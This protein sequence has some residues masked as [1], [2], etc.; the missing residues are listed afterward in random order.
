VKTFFVFEAELRILPSN[1]GSWVSDPT[2]WSSFETVLAA[3]RSGGY[4]GMGFVL[5]DSGLT[6]VDLDHCIENDIIQPWAQDVVD[7]L[8]SY[9]EISPSGSGIHIII[10]AQLPQGNKRRRKG[11]IEMYCHGR[12]FCVTSKHLNGT[13]AEIEGRQDE[14]EALHREIFG[15]REPEPPREVKCG[16]FDGSDEDLLSRARQARNGG[17]F[18]ALYDRGDISAY[19]GD[20]SAADQALVNMLAFWCGPDPERID[21]LFRQ[22]ALC[23]EKWI[24]RA[25]YRER[26]IAAALSK[27]TEHFS[28]TQTSKTSKAETFNLTDSGNAERFTEQHGAKIRHCRKWNNWLFFDGNHWNEEIGTETTHQLALETARRILDEAKA[29]GIGKAER[30]EPI[31]WSL[32]SESAARLQAM[33][34]VAKN[35]P[36]IAAVAGDFD[37]DPWLF[38]CQNGTIDLKTGKLREHRAKDMLT[39]ISPVDYDPEVG[40]DLWDKFLDAV[41]NGDK[42]K[43]DFLRRAVG[44]ALTGVTTEE[45]LFFVHGAT[46]TG[47]STFIEAVKAM[48]GD[49]AITADFETF[50]RRKDIGTVRNDIARLHGA[51]LVGSLEMEEGKHLAESLVKTLTGGDTIATRFLYKESFEFKPQFK[52]WLAANHAPRVRDD[53]AA[54]WRR[55]IRI[56]FEHEIPEGDQ[57]PRVKATLRDPQIAGPA[58]LAWAVKGCLAWQKHG[59]AVP[60]TIKRATAEYR[61]SQDPLRDFYDEWCEF[62]QASY[63]PVKELRTRYDEF[64][65]ESGIKYPLSPK[66]FNARL[67]AKGCRQG[68]K[69]HPNDIGTEKPTRCWIGVN[70]RSEPACE[71]TTDELTDDQRIPI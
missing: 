45:K 61:E 50:L 10:K 31:K 48:L 35:L 46:A 11:P 69:N 40:L 41:T 54:I 4:N 52:L 71:E 25:D 56:P 14:I 62:G 26:T 7:R 1:C 44:Y 29:E 32:K 42:E 64:A 28:Q 63:V 30:E 51:R 19:D 27:Q 66:D 59:L 39:K 65:K 9:S 5:T 37:K 8:R 21:R 17:K 60:E 20:D 53:D 43:K 3:M 15:E 24:S 57:D 38:N 6:G 16:G 67:R 13:P 33:L 70:L 34:D 58:I 12:Y 22:S 2:T 36:P 47:K 18:S 55:I 68:K 49:Y 23:R